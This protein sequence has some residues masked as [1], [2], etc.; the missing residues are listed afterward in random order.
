MHD[1]VLVEV[2]E[3]QHYLGAYEL[4][5]AFSKPFDL[6]YVVVDVASRVVIKKEVNSKL[7][8]EHEVHRVDER[9]RCLEENLFL[10]F[11]VLDLF[12]LEEDVF[13]DAF[14]RV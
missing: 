3:S 13:V 2:A 6:V 9:M 4:D 5:C 1:V 12:L 10:V 7:V 14:H 11:D 8:L